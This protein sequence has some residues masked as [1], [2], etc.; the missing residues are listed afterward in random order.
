MIGKMATRQIWPVSPLLLL[1]TLILMVASPT[2]SGG[3]AASLDLPVNGQK[4]CG[5]SRASSSAS[6]RECS[7]IAGSSL[8]VARTSDTVR[9]CSGKALAAIPV[10]VNLSF[11]SSPEFTVPSATFIW[12][13]HRLPYGCHA[14]REVAGKVSVR[15]AGLGGPMTV[16]LSPS[17]H[18]R[19]FWGGRRNV[20]N[21]QAT[22]RGD[23]FLERLGCVQRAV[24]ILRYRLV[25]ASGRVASQRFQKVPVKSDRKCASV[26]GG[27]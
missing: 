17:G 22:F 11:G 25:S 6:D 19:T 12:S 1:S 14:Y 2:I 10:V 27:A 8:N 24:G 18:M 7:G 9:S 20:H 13:G 15:F 5:V 23:V 4:V 26:Q 21:A 3:E 16:G